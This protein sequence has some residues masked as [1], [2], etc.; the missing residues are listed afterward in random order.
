MG[1]IL[2]MISNY[3]HD[4]AVAL[5][6]ANIFAVYITGRFL[7]RNPVKDKIVPRLFKKLALVTYAAF[8]YIIIGGAVRAYN[9]M[10]FEWNPAVGKGQVTAL[11]IKHIILFTV[12]AFGIIGHI[13]YHK[14][15]GISE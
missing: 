3:F 7:D 8:A 13:R 1:K 2:L 9:F 11:I 12:T 6:A 5:L 4:L 10:D 14:R 15:Y